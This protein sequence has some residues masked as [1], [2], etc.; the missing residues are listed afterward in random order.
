MSRPD[1]P[2]LA[3][4]ITLY[5]AEMGGGRSVRVK[6]QYR[7]PNVPGALETVG[8]LTLSRGRLREFVRFLTAG[9]APVRF[10]GPYIA[11]RQERAS[12]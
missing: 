5:C 2:T 9:G 10:A 8:V 11:Q 7:N 4:R 6:V 1:D 12:A 3:E